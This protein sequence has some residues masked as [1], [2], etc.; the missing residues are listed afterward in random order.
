MLF[1]ELKHPPRPLL[2]TCAH[3]RPKNAS[4]KTNL[5]RILTIFPLQ[6]FLYSVFCI[7][8]VP[9]SGLFV[10]KIFLYNLALDRL[11]AFQQLNKR[12]CLA[13]PSRFVILNAASFLQTQKHLFVL[14]THKGLAGYLA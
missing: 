11:L 6:Y 14:L 2:L 8:N 13:T 9:A 3:P 12:S 7:K 10:V 5:G 4:F 1:S